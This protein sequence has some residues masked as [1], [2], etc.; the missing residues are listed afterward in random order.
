M[1]AKVLA[2]L[3]RLWA[4]IKKYWKW[5]LLP[6]GILLAIAQIVSIFR[7]KGKVVVVPH[8]G[9]LGPAIAQKDQEVAEK[10]QEAEAKAQEQIKEIEKKHEETLAKLDGEQR[11]TYQELKKQG[12]QAIADWLI[13]VGKG[14]K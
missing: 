13:A 9:T 2:W 7:G 5:I 4:W 1:T 14:Q 6:V 8:D 11:V 12:P 10:V 3:K